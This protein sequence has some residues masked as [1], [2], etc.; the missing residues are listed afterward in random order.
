MA[1]MMRYAS[2]MQLLSDDA[3]LSSPSKFSKFENGETVS[4]ALVDCLSNFGLFRCAEYRCRQLFDALSNCRPPSENISCVPPGIFARKFMTYIEA[5]TASVSPPSKS[6]KGKAPWACVNVAVETRTNSGGRRKV[7]L[8]WIS[9]LQAATKGQ[10]KRSAGAFTGP[11]VSLTEI[12][13]AGNPQ[14][15]LVGSE[16]P[17]RIDRNEEEEHHAPHAQPEVARRLQ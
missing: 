4:V 15:T 9:A 16:A 3:P 7:D 6:L 17:S 8:L 12:A 11:S 2:S 5:N 13:S 14:I 1:A 10:K